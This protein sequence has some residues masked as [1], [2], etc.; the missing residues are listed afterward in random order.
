MTHL[1]LC[2]LA[3]D[4]PITSSES[5]MIFATS[6]LSLGHGSTHFCRMSPCGKLTDQSLHM[7][8]L[9][10]FEYIPSLIHMLETISEASV[11]GGRGVSDRWG[12]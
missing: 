2:Y 1:A 6:V 10:W 11:G 7:C 12:L 5:G 9:P 4:H 8:Q 3:M